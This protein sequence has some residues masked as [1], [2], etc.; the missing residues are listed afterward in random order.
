MDTAPEPAPLTCHLAALPD[1]TR[2]RSL[3]DQ[4][5]TAISGAAELP[6]GY[7]YSVRGDQ[8]S[9]AELGDWISLERQCCPFL[10]FEVS[11]S[12]TDTLWWL[13]LT[14]PEGVKPLLERE[15]PA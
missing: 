14:G 9:L 1:R 15:F 3:S 8:L 5:R 11:V 2:Y 13:T 4:L 7:S 10:N 6:D 12:G